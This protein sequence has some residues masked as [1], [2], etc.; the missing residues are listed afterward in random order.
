MGVAGCM[1][2]G[3]EAPADG[4]GSAMDGGASDGGDGGDGVNGGSATLGLFES[5]SAG[6]SMT[7]EE[8]RN[9][10][11]VGEL[12][13]EGQTSPDVSEISGS[14]SVEGVVSRDGR[15]AC[16]V[17]IRYDEP[18]GSSDRQL[19]RVE[20]YSS[21]DDYVD[22]VYYDTNDVR[23]MQVTRDGNDTSFTLYDEE[24]E[25]MEFPSSGGSMD[26]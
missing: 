14:V 22:M 4:N 15:E 23:R 9:Q 19:N 8:M 7:F 5:C 17:V 25:E 12:F 11:D 26:G 20:I 2:G 6:Q 24:G 18:V 10:Y 16:H 1:D 21:G 13:Q 3:G